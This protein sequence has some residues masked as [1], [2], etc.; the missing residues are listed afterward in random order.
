MIEELKKEFARM[1][2][3]S[4]LSSPGTLA[5]GILQKAAEIEGNGDRIAEAKALRK[6]IDF[7][8]EEGELEIMI[9][10]DTPTNAPA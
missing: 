4:G 7:V 9:L 6:M 8:E 5:L 1:I 2:E 10:K 3:E